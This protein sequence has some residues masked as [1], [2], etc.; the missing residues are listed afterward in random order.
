ML[1]TLETE[2][3][4]LQPLELAD[5]EQ[6]QPLFAQWDVVKFLNSKVPWPFP[7]DGVYRYYRDVALP[8]MERGDEWHWTLRLKASPSEVIG[9]I[10]LF[11]VDVHRGFW[12]GLPWHGQG[13]MT[14]AA[15][16]VTGFWFDELDMPVLRTAKAVENTSSRR[17][18]ARMG[19]RVVET[20]ESEYVS[21]TY[22]TEVWE[23][24]AEE[25]NRMRLKWA[26]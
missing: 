5:A 15:F 23:I 24:T 8:A 22:L 13:L 9:A 2:R 7:S 1:P 11:R 3:L 12:L 14:E 25:W 20:K 10:G 26:R 6:V 4:I 17:I 21:G 19:M 18:S 16:A